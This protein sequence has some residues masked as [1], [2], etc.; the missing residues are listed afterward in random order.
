MLKTKNV[1]QPRV[2]LVFQVTVKN[3]QFILITLN[4]LVNFILGVVIPAVKAA[5]SF[6]LYFNISEVNAEIIG[7]TLQEFNVMNILNIE[8]W[9]L[10]PSNVQVSN[11]GSAMMMAIIVFSFFIMT[12]LK[13]F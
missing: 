8:H 13:C 4:K 10:P 1:F 5:L 6:H 9:K 3:A 11:M 2:S 12:L 7:L